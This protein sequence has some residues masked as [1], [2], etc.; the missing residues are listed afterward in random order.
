MKYLK[1]CLLLVCLNLIAG[2]PVMA[3]VVNVLDV[4]SHQNQTD[5]QL[6]VQCDQ[7]VEPLVVQCLID[8]DGNSQTGFTGGFDLL[9]ESD[10]LYRFAGTQSSAWTWNQVCGIGRKFNGTFVTYSIPMA[11][12]KETTLRMQNRTPHL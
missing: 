9:I 6:K 7:P 1:T 2:A 4:I 8:E 12:L 3:Q 11:S 5:W 10:L